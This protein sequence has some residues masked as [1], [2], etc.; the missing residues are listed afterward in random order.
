VGN[1]EGKLTAFFGIIYDT[2]VGR[3]ELGNELSYPTE[4]GEF[5]D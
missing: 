2:S 1:K 5:V 3:C 4:D